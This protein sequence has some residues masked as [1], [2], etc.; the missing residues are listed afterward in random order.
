[1]AVMKS[2]YLSRLL[3]SKIHTPDGEFIGVLKELISTNAERPEV[4]ACV[5][6]TRDH[7]LKTLDWRGISLN[8]EKK[9]YVV[10]CAEMIEAQPPEHSIYLKRHI[11]DKQIVDM[12]GKK[13]V[14]VND[15]RMAAISSGFYV[16]A[17]DVGMEGLMRRLD[18][19]RPTQR[20]LEI[21]G[22][23]LPSKL[24]LWSNME[25]IG[26]PLD[27]LRLS[28]T[29]SK[30]STLHPSELADIIEELDVK[31][32][33]AIFNSLDHDR[34]ADVLEEL[35]S[36]VQYSILD[37]LP[38]GKAADVLEKMPA[39]EVADI[40]DELH[41]DKAEQLLSEMDQETSE[42]VRELMEYPEN[43]VG[44]LM[45]TDY[46]SFQ[47]TMTVE[48]TLAELRRLKPESDTIY[49]LYVVD[50][51]N[52]LSAILSLRDLVVSQPEVRLEQIMNR[53]VIYVRDDDPINSLVE[54]I[55]KYSLLAVPVVDKDAVMLGVVI[56][57][58]VV[59]ELLRPKK[60][61]L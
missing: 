41:E 45:S 43:T 61:R 47:E 54:I 9:A 18:L 4:V 36:D 28:T 25:P 14:R 12:D 10:T 51:E 6:S 29:A 50:D 35:E 49:Y 8:K 33:A 3:N 5:V 23:S 7:E 39:D 31:T 17:V 60:K 2:F 53:K 34:A 37:Q 19:A 1:M 13:V 30:L 52:R 59:Y 48:E 20:M 15:I 57:D 42:E 46:I 26:P 55:S 44:S 32:G 11:L 21:F 38:V 56:I 27:N 58:D 16:V 24:I 22:K 40:L